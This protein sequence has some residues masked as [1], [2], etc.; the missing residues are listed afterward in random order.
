MIAISLSPNTSF[1]DVFLSL[2]ILFCPWKWYRKSYTEMLEKAFA[3][4]FGS[5]YYALSLNSGRSALY[6]ILQMLNL[7][8]ME[9]ALQGLTCV[10]V[11]NAVLWADA[12]P[13]YI[14]IDKS[15][16]MDPSDLSKKITKNTR[17]IIVQHTFGIPADMDAITKIG[18]QKGILVIEDCAHSLGALYKN[19][20]VG[21]L[22]DISFF[23]FG[24]DKIISS[25]FG[26]MILCKDKKTYQVLKKMRDGLPQ[27][28]RFWVMQQLLHPI[29]FSI[30]LPLYRI[31]IGKLLL[32]LFQKAHLLSKAV[33][34]V[35]KKTKKPPYFPSQM[36]GALSIL[37]LYQFKKLDIF[38]ENR[39][40]IAS[41]YS[42]KLGKK[43][44]PKDKE[45]VWLRFPLEIQNRDSL[46]NFAKRY[47]ILLG[48]WYQALVF[49][50][51][52]MS[53]V[54]Y[55]KGICPKAEGVSN[56][57]INFPTHPKMSLKDAYT[58]VSVFEKWQNSQ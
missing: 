26:G 23:S 44:L 50:V 13:L 57:I 4:Y 10:V 1:K 28:G 38:N 9:V 2:K 12:K 32:V 45:A 41:F 33:Y 35:E 17:A 7:K 36:P 51:S 29:L 39:K 27:P 18:R 53:L 48:D 34:E 49:P 6:L 19:K 16:N 54:G 46:F 5:S 15:Y 43:F 37:A 8:K 56:E 3:S 58:V 11:P 30:I 20:K 25:V 47:G 14:D 21:T 40:R 24:R 31:K 22:G 52:Q 42:R 55:Q